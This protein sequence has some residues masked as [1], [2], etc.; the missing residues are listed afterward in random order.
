MGTRGREI[1]WSQS[2]SNRRPRQCHCRALPTELWPHGR[3]GRIGASPRA[4]NHGPPARGSAA[5]G[6]K[7]TDSRRKRRSHEAPE[8]AKGPCGPFVGVGGGGG[9]RTP[10]RRFYIP[11]STCVARRLIS[12]RGNTTRKAHLG[13]SRFG[14]SLT[15]PTARFG[16]SVMMTLHRR[17]R[18]QAGSGL[19]P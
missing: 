16:D 10:V 7:G 3:R 6:A 1:W 2:G 9:N 19:R 11:G 12:S 8:T 17:A 5:C 14:V 18:T 4:V 15:R 13:T